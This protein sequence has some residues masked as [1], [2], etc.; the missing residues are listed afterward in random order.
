MASFCRLKESV[1]SVI[2]PLSPADRGRLPIRLKREIVVMT[3]DHLH[4]EMGRDSRPVALKPLRAIAA[5]T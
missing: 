2:S 1:S 3:D 5:H 4:H